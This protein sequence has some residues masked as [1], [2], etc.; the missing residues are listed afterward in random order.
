M[1]EKA[2][3]RKG[4][5][6]TR[7]RRHQPDETR[8]EVTRSPQG[9]HQDLR[10][11]NPGNILYLQQTIGNQAVQRLLIARDPVAEAEAPA[12][13]ADV[14]GPLSE[15][16]VVKALSFYAMR[17]DRYT[18]DII[19]EIQFAVG[20]VPTGKMT[21]VDVQMVAKKQEELNVDA[22]PKLKIDGMAGPRTLPSIFKFGLSEEKSVSSYTEKAK[23]KWDNPGGKSEAQIAEDIVNELINTRLAELKMPPL[24]VKVEDDLGSRGS[25]R[26]ED[27]TMR[28]D[29]R[30]FKPGRFHDLRDTTATI[31]HEARHAE[32]DFRI[33][34]MLAQKGRTAKQINERIGLE[35]TVADAAVKAKADLT[36]IQAV[37]A[38]GWFDSL[39]SEEGINRRIQNNQKLD[40]AFQEREAACKLFKEDPSDKHSVKLEKAKDK[41]REA[42]AE[43]DDMPH[44]FD[45]ERLETRVEQLFG[46]GEDHDDPCSLT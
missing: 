14:S 41:L 40:K 32:H 24:N 26:G 42:I 44:E 10:Q 37:I 12:P 7:R 25:F 9:A 20:S 23:E 31:Y 43:H 34:Q 36:P 6:S 22:E 39:Y 16:E 4:R 3:A 2:L 33:A 5:F 30:Q 15:G 35:E 29:S 13:A 38:Q 8:H 27:W 11:P 45:P 1:A 18:R 19:M 17:P 28:L 21:P 46:E